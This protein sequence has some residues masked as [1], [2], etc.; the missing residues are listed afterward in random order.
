MRCLAVVVL[1]TLITPSLAQ[2]HVEEQLELLK[3]EVEKLRQE[4][5][6]LRLKLAQANLNIA[7]LKSKVQSAKSESGSAKDHEKDGE[8]DDEKGDAPTL[9]SRGKSWTVTLISVDEPDEFAIRRAVSSKEFDI[10]RIRSSIDFERRRLQGRS[11]GTFSRFS[12]NEERSQIRR[13]IAKKESELRFALKE[14]RELKEDQD[15][16][17]TSV[18]C[19][20]KDTKSG[21]IVKLIASGGAKT[22]AEAMKVGQT[23]RV[24]GF[25]RG[26]ST[27]LIR[28]IAQPD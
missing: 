7:S 21:Q 20:A 23:Y 22:A 28:A 17:K 12:N 3:R 10:G 5:R 27:L 4:N 9:T 24:E 18:F 13:A 25:Q 16:A 11:S 1:L 19:T 26:T 8:K 15:G 6:A 14:L 2:Q